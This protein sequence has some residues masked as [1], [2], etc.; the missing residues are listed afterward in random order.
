V[1]LR[2]LVLVGFALLAASGPLRSTS[3]PATV[4]AIRTSAQSRTTYLAHARIWRDPGTLS[5]SEL[6]EGPARTFPYTAE[7]ATSEAGIACTYAKP[8]REMGGNSAKFECRTP[9][10]RVLR[11]KYWDL[12][13]RTGNR[14]AFAT[15]AAS[16]LMW[17]LGFDTL[18]AMSLTVRCDRCPENP[19]AGTGAPRARRYAGML[20]GAVPGPAILS[21]GNF[22]QGWSW[23]ELDKAIRSLPAGPERASQRTHFD[24]LALLGV[25]MEHGDRKPEQQSLYCGGTVDTAAGDARDMSGRPILFEHPGA[26]ACPAPA[27]AIV[28][29][30][31]TFGGAGH[32]SSETTAKMNLPEWQKKPV[33]VKSTGGECHGDLVVSLAAGHDGEGNPAI[34]EEGRVFLLEQL[35][36]LTPDHV[37]AIFRAARVDLLQPRNAHDS[38]DSD[39]AI[40][41]WASAFQDKVRQIDAQRCQPAR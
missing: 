10:G 26:S 40:E 33:F 16:R 20:E 30:G 9:E 8:G 23:L 29:A 39:H 24:A 41:D 13:A 4:A 19:H 38:P 1:A 21:G 2:Q 37:R 27:V 22:A 15:V 32:T 3:A 17:A 6:L 5:P 14:E 25:L 12:E 35:H 28:D 18:P 36:R 31:A 7:Q 34:S 11:L